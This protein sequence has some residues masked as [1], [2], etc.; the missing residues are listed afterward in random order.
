MK[1]MISDNTALK[2]ILDE[3]L[4]V[5][6]YLW[7]RGWAERNAGNLSIEVT[8]H[9]PAEKSAGSSGPLQKLESTY[10]DLA[11][12]CFLVTGSGRRFRDMRKNPALNACILRIS[13]DGGA[14]AIIWGGQAGPDFRPTSEFPAHLRLHEHLR[15]TNAEEKV[16]LHTHPIELIALTHLPEYRDEAALNRALWCTHPEVKYNLPK[17]VGFVPYVIPGSE[18]LAQATL[19]CFQRGYPVVLWE[20]HGSVTRAKE[21]LVAFDLVDIANKAASI[22]LLC[23][24]VGHTLTGLS[25]E[26]LDE[27][28]RTFGLK[29]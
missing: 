24:S 26:Q 5:S 25:R 23:R 14:Y 21:P 4:E 13:E 7:E 11:N 16:V 17:G 27:I 1:D 2:A 28:V 12:C 6:G 15:R 18:E 9:I 8:E 22:V 20:I 29:E 3:M 10:P 19:A